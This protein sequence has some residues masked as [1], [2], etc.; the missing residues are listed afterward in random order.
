MEKTQRNQQQQQQ[1]TLFRFIAIE[2]KISLFSVEHE[3]IDLG[4][5]CKNPMTLDI[6]CSVVLLVKV[7]VVALQQKLQEPPTYN[8][9]TLKSVC[10]F[11]TLYIFTTR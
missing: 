11:I 3:K 8:V 4:S 10:V 9:I 7:G 6:S 1:S 5:S 2:K